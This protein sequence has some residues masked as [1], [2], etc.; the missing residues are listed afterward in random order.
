MFKVCEGEARRA[1]ELLTALWDLAVALD[2]AHEFR[3]TR[4]K[5]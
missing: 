1:I 3:R 2:D 4:H 5:P